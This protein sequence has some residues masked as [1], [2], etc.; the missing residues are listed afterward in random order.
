MYSKCKRCE[1]LEKK[2]SHETF[3][4][5]PICI[6]LP[7]KSGVKNS[8]ELCWFWAERRKKKSTTDHVKVKPK[9]IVSFDL[10]M[11]LMRQREKKGK[12]GWR[13]KTHIKAF[14][15]KITI[16]WSERYI[17]DATAINGFPNHLQFMQP[18]LF[19]M[20][21]CSL[22]ASLSQ[23]WES[24]TKA[25][26]RHKCDAIENHWNRFLISERTKRCQWLIVRGTT[27]HSIAWSHIILDH[28]CFQLSDCDAFWERE[29]ENTR[30]TK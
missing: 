23:T 4:G 6:W 12:Y 28:T 5:T 8:N 22:S 15:F 19:P 24:R 17:V 16:T 30:I 27:K 11:L 20:E 13:Q 25:N 29:R 2:P 14:A 9:Q 10:N 21:Y 7:V 18:N 3:I 1:K 26:S